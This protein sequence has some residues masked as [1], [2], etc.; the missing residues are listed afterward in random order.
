MFQPKTCDMYLNQKIQMKVSDALDFLRE[1]GDE[2]VDLI[3]TDP[4]W[5]VNKKEYGIYGKDFRE[6]DIFFSWVESV[7]IECYRVLKKG[8]AL[9]VET[10][11]SWLKDWIES[12]EKVGFDFR[13]PIIL[14]LTN[15]MSRRSFV[16][17]SKYSF[18]LWFGKKREDGKTAKV[19]HPYKDIIP[20]ALVSS[21]SEGWTYP[22]PK[23]VKVYSKLIKMFSE[24]ND[25]VLDPFVGSGTTAIACKLKRRRF[26][27]CD[28]NPEYV[29]LAQERVGKEIS[30]HKL[31][32]I[33]G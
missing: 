3:L 8:R 19:L 23:S 32:D 6:R 20:W 31:V 17:Y 29:A 13:Q 2:T 24:E 22:N 15:G 11:F 14:Y 7:F 9:L 26:S 5:N 12:G 18:C 33:L 16:G 28:I 4:P 1:F 10:G 30:S 27:G 21:K 25:L